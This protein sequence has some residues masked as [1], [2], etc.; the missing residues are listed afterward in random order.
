MR[1]KRLLPAA[2]SV[3]LCLQMIMPV[4][5]FTHAA[6]ETFYINPSLSDGVTLNSADNVSVKGIR[7]GE[8]VTFT[9]TK[10]ITLSLSF[11]EGY[12]Y[13]PDFST[14]FNGEDLYTKVTEDGNNVNITYHAVKG[15]SV[16]AEMLDGVTILA[17][18][19]KLPQIKIDVDG[20]IENVTKEEWTNATI[21]IVE[22]SKKFETGNYG[23]TGRIKG[24]GNHSWQKEQKPYSINLDEKA[25]LLGL[26]NTRRYALVTPASD[27]SLIRNY[28]TYKA[29]QR[30]EGIEY[31][32][33]CELVEVYFNGDFAGIY[34]LCERVR[35]ESDKINLEDAT[36]TNL[37]GGYVIEKN[38]EGKLGNDP[39]DICFGCPYQV[40]DDMDLFTVIDPEEPTKEMTQMLEEHFEKLDAA[41]MGKSNE[42]YKKYIDVDSWVDFVIMNEVA[43]NVDGNFKTS[44]FMI[45]REN[46]DVIEMTSLWDFDLAYGNADWDNET[47]YNHSNDLT[48]GDTVEDFMIINSSSP[49]H[50]AL[51]Y[52]H[53]DFKAALVERYEQYRSTI[54][55]DMYNSIHELGAYL[56]ARVSELDKFI[57]GD[58][59]MEACEDLENWL[60]KRLAWLDE[61]WLGIKADDEKQEEKDKWRENPDKAFLG[62]VVK[63]ADDDLDE[64]EVVREVEDA[65]D[66]VLDAAEDLLDN[67]KATREDC[68]S[69]AFELLRMCGI[70]GYKNIDKKGVELLSEYASSMGL[71]AD[72]VSNANA[73][74]KESRPNADKLKE[75]W[76]ALINDMVETPDSFMANRLFELYGSENTEN[77]YKTGVD[78]YEKAKEDLLS[79]VGN[80]AS[81]QGDLD[82]VSAEIARTVLLLEENRFSNNSSHSPNLRPGNNTSKA[83]KEETIEKEGFPWGVVGIVA[84][85]IAAVGIFTSLIIIK[86]H[87][88]KQQ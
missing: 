18:A 73:L 62:K 22:G 55:E 26:C 46:S 6:E 85:I 44:C 1:I 79:A 28:I 39:L 64:A 61:Q 13:A 15:R 72:A 17:S 34:A 52:D 40:H 48:P 77:C 10:D 50:K 21:E 66:S 83:E 38:V 43:K 30:L 12:S 32:V 81:G 86:K 35:N 47:D 80:T 11:E 63:Y 7:T 82:A 49:W 65:F 31:N 9:E 74:T 68:D 25:S 36:P 69:M 70:I 75:A 51:Y 58:D 37:N 5:T 60:G 84:G 8:R 33:D 88:N 53:P 87:K 2:L 71:A 41:V 29:A 14:L 59:L 45:K 20:S 76:V 23:C 67:K 56:N 24:R 78:R 42:D 27:N 16:S 3:A 54:F 57:D 4:S 19:K